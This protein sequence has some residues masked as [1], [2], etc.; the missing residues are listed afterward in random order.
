MTGMPTTTVTQAEIFDLLIQQEAWI[1][2]LYRV[3]QNLFPELDAFWEQMAKEEH[4]HA[5]V[6]SHLA[7]RVDNATC[8]F[9]AR[10]F[11][12]TGLCTS[13]DYIRKQIQVA[14]T[15]PI[16]LVK[17]LATAMD[18]ETGL[19]EKEFFTVVS[20]DSTANRAAFQVLAGQTQEHRKRIAA[21]LAEARRCPA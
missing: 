16:S 8:F 18:L 20:S 6:L 13:C 4:G 17:A 1:E 15:E 10:K 9:E 12:A 19:I 5:E 2:Q 3:Y 7:K 14:S 11:N 21:F